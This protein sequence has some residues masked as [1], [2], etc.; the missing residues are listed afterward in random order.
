M[1]TLRKLEDGLKMGFGTGGGK[2][3]MD[4]SSRGQVGVST[5]WQWTQARLGGRWNGKNFA[6]TRPS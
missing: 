5:Q 2:S 6:D 4:G 1:A 3:I